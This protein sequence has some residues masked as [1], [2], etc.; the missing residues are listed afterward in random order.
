[1]VG[2]HLWQC[3]DNYGPL[4]SHNC[5]AFESFYGHLIKLKNSNASYSTKML[6][7]LG[8]HHISQY[9][10]SKIELGND[11]WQ[12][13]IMENMGILIRQIQNKYFYEKLH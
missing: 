5:F 2:K 1:M 13:K 4:I 7:A 10:T 3:C 8:H 9:I 12:G 11:T 6:F